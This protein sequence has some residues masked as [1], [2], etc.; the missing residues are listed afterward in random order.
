MLATIY[1][2]KYYCQIHCLYF[3]EYGRKKKLKKKSQKV[4]MLHKTLPFTDYRSSMID[5]KQNG[6]H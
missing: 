1:D 5:S 6:I 4:S 3:P 2:W